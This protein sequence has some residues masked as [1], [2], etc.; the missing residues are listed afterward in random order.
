MLQPGFGMGHQVF[1]QAKTP[2]TR[3]HHIISPWAT[4]GKICFFIPPEARDLAKAT[5]QSSTKCSKKE[6]QDLHRSLGMCLSRAILQGPWDHGRM[7]VQY[8]SMLSCCIARIWK[9][10]HRKCWRVTTD[11]VRASAMRKE[12]SW[13]TEQNLSKSKILIKVA[14][15]NHKSHKSNS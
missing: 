2:A 5:L 12:C 13:Q 7:G 8:M 14:N 9:I 1:H 3:Q 4:C 11:G 6:L 15:L 10:W